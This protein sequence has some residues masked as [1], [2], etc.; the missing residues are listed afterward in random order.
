[1]VGTHINRNI[2]WAEQAKPFMTYVARVSYMLQQGSPVMDLAYLLP[3]GAPSTMPFWGAG[4]LPAPPKGYDYDYVNTDILLHKMS[5][6]ADGSV[7]VAGSP[8]MP[9]GM[10]YRVLVLPPTR[11]RTRR[12]GCIGRRRTRISILSRTRP[13]RRCI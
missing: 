1:M 7:R 6:G 12:F 2:T 10:S 5:V 9:D 4:L 8:A 13:I 3:Q 11:W